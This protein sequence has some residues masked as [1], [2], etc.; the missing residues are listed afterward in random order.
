M[1]EYLIDHTYSNDRLA[2]IFYNEETQ[3]FRLW[4]RPA[5]EHFSYAY[6]LKTPENEKKLHEWLK[7]DEFLKVNIGWKDVRKKHPIWHKEE[8]FI[9]VFFTTPLGVKEFMSDDEFFENNIRYYTRFTIDEKI[10]FGMPYEVSE[11]KIKSIK[12]DISAEERTLY[13]Q[14]TE[15]FNKKLVGNILTKLMTP[16]I[17]MPYIAIDAEMKSRG[18]VVPNPLTATE[19]VI[20]LSLLFRND[21]EVK[22]IQLA[23]SKK[24]RPY[25][26]DKPNGTVIRAIR[27]KEYTIEWFDDEKDLLRRFIELILDTKYRMVV[28]FNGD[29]FDL[30]YIHYRCRYLGL[31]SPFRHRVFTRNN[32]TFHDVN[33]E[34]RNSVTREP[35]MKQWKIH[36]DLY[37]FFSQTYIKNYAYQGI[38]ANNKLETIGQ[39]LLGRGKVKHDTPIGQMS[40][41]DLIQYNMEDV[42]LLDD[43]IQRNNNQVFALVFLLMRLGMEPFSECYRKAISSKVQHLILEWTN[44]WGYINPRKVDMRLKDEYGYERLGVDMSTLPSKYGGAIV[45]EPVPGIHFNIEGRDFTGLYTNTIFNQNLSFETVNCGHTECMHNVVPEVGHY[46]CTKE[47]GIMSQI[48]GLITTARTL[49]FKPKAKEDSYFSPIEQILKVYGNAIYGVFGAFFFAYNLRILAE[50][51]TAFARSALKR[52][53]KKGESLGMKAVY[54]DTDSAFFANYTEETMNELVKWVAKELGLELNLDYNLTYIIISHRKKNYLGITTDGRAIIKGFKIKKRNSPPLITEVGNQII[55]MLTRVKE[56]EDIDRVKTSIL[57]T[58]RRMYKNIWEKKGDI[59]SYAITQQVRMKIKDYKVLGPHVRAAI[60]EAEMI[61]AEL[62]EG[63]AGNPE[64]IIEPGTL[65]PYIKCSKTAIRRP[66]GSGTRLS[67][68]PLSIAELDDIEPSQYHKELVS[69]MSQILDP[70]GISSKDYIVNDPRKPTLDKFIKVK[71]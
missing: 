26:E 14:L 43:L 41:L 63:M 17:R 60:M 71:T 9:K 53:V 36:F 18:N 66:S 51:I 33:I 67:V 54:G 34:P 12:R 64:D 50:S 20:S 24:A 37:K 15:K 8:D 55:D 65:Q 25:L 16:T 30:Q 42:V 38:Y 19:P 28:T 27:K 21:N 13:N 57:L 23:L 6:M 39:A 48:V 11:R 45:I 5:Q 29:N 40:L 32:R 3:D 47:K 70:F 44:N 2:L 58:L 46:V 49:Y 22:K 56:P 35:L 59:N 31:W 52:M 1:S 7:D 10:A 69:S 4:Q 61:L 68:L 62:P